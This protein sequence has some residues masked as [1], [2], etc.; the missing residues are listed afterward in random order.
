[1]R[2]VLL[3][4]ENVSGRPTAIRHRLLASQRDRTRRPHETRRIGQRTA[5]ELE[6]EKT[7]RIDRPRQRQPFSVTPL[8]TEAVVV[9]RI[10][11]ENHRAM[12]DRLRAGKPVPDQRAAEATRA[13]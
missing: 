1:M 3:G 8:E 12:P 2:Q 7:R 11:D 9:G 13:W 10:A 5:G 4:G 6:P